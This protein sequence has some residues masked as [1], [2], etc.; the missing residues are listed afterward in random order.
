MK[1][2]V[3]L[4][5]SFLLVILAVEDDSYNEIDGAQFIDDDFFDDGNNPPENRIPDGAAIG[6]S[7][8]RKGQR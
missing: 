5:L 2:P 7:I 8:K 6:V 4:V 3:A 1:F